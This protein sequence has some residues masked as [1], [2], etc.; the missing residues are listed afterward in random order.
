MTYYIVM[1]MNSLKL[2]VPDITKPNRSRKTLSVT[3]ILSQP[4]Q[5]EIEVNLILC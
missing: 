3:F 5:K 2:E 4:I 1:K